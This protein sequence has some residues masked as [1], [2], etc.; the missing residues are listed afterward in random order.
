MNL[1]P[2]YFHIMTY[3]Y[4][5]IHIKYS[6]FVSSSIENISYAALLM[7]HTADR[8]F[9]WASGQHFHILCCHVANFSCS[10]AIFYTNER[11]SN[12]RGHT[13]VCGGVCVH[14]NSHMFHCITAQHISQQTTRKLKGKMSKTSNIEMLIVSILP[15]YIYSKE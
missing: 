14:V 3:K 1:I 7:I 8:L 15:C 5:Y 6:I 12:R 10:S 4:C 2:I 13:G 9:Y 11:E